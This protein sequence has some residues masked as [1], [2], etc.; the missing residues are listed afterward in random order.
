MEINVSIA[1]LK[2]HNE[3]FDKNVDKLL[4]LIDKLDFHENHILLLPELWS[5]G[6]TT[7][8]LDASINNLEIINILSEKSTEKKI[9]ICGSYILQDDHCNFHNRLIVIF[10][11]I[12]P[13]AKYNKT[14]LFKLMNEH[15]L[16][17]PGNKLC[18][19]N[20][21]DQIFGLSIC[22]DL[23]FPEIY[24]QYA[25]N[26]TQFHL[27]PMQWPKIRI[28]QLNKLLMARAI[29]NQAYFISANSIGLSGKTEFGGN[30]QI[31][32]FMGNVILNMGNLID[33]IGYAKLDTEPLEIW[34]KDF[35][36]LNDFD[37]FQYMNIE[38]KSFKSKSLF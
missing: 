20:L 17:S 10:P 16:F 36:V 11:D 7:K 8:L 21:F 34:R 25:M 23:R 14:K 12:G 37:E 15:N 28:D 22:Y 3:E 32:D 5:T 35:P 27:I 6:Y 38:H 9:V 19:V 26:K 18:S 33:E 1:Q 24:R 29:E 13:I 4:Y 30:S 31:I 2:I